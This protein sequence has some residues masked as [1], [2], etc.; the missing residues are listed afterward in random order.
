MEQETHNT[1]DCFAVIIVKAE[2]GWMEETATFE[3]YLVE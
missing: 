2:T 3:P 1:E